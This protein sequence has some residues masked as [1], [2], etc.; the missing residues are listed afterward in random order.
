MRTRYIFPCL[1]LLCAAC[2]SAADE[3]AAPV[4]ESP[5]KGAHTYLLRYHFE[6]GEILRWKVVHRA[7]VNTTVSGTSQTAETTS[8]SVKLWKVLPATDRNQFRFEHQVEKVEMRQQLT[9]REEVIYNS[10]TGA[11]PPPGFEDAAKCVGVPLALVTIDQQGNVLHREQQKASP[12]E[13]NGQI[14]IP[15]PTEAVAV[16]HVWS[17]PYDVQVILRSGEAHQ[18]KTRQRFTLEN[19]ERQIASIQVET[20]VLS[21]IDNPEIEAQLIQREMSGIVKFDIPSGRIIEQRMDLD[22]NV[23]GF[24]GESSSLHYVMRFTEELLPVEK[25]AAVTPVA[26]PPAGAAGGFNPNRI[27]RRPAAENRQTPARGARRR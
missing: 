11:A 15:L 4:Q 10:E 21:P 8:T 17:F 26:A 20:Q 27:T 1:F 6:P 13:N 19:V 14:V 7:L 9:G 18:I 5:E 23:V 16:G 22:K 3:S 25:T 2:A 12:H 24:S